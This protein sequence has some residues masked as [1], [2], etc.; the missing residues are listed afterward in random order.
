MDIQVH[1]SP[2][3]LE[4]GGEWRVCTRSETKEQEINRLY[5]RA[6]KSVKGKQGPKE[7]KVAR[8]YQAGKGGK[9]TVDTRQK[10]DKRGEARAKLK[11]TGKKQGSGHGGKY[12]GK[13]K[14]G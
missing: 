9:G 8:K 1:L 10:A 4:E 12:K 5:S 13:P 11:K 14:R 3:R 2:I 6:F 7:L